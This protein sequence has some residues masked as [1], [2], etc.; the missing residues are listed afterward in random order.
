VSKTAKLLREL[1]AIPSVNPGLLPA[2]DHH[3]GE[4]QVGEFIAGIA[5]RA[6]LEVEFRPVAPARANLLAVLAPQGKPRQRVLLAPHLDTVG[7]PSA[8]PDLF[9]PRVLNGRMYGRGACDTKG[10]IAVML[11]AL[12]HV[13]GIPNRPKHTEIVF[14]GLVDEEYLQTGSR[15]L[16]DSGYTADLA[17]VGEPTRL[18][19]VT[20]HKGAVWLQIQT[21]GKAAHGAR[22][23]LGRNA[24]Y[25][26]AK[27]VRILEDEYPRKYLARRHALLG[28]PTISVGSIKGGNQPNIV[29]AECVI[30]VDR[31]TLPG[32]TDERVIAQ[33]RG[34]FRRHR[35]TA[36]VR[37]LHSVPCPSL[38][39]D[40]RLPLVRQFMRAAGQKQPSG[41][42]FFSDAAV[43]ASGGIPSVL[44][45]PGDIAQAH[46]ADEWVALEQLERGRAILTRFLQSLD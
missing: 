10:S 2:G 27:V 1:I 14:A 17:I 16:A 7:V 30:T 5:S 18:K 22:P 45:G 39:T 24:V 4:Q 44:F 42:V 23:E 6:G 25:E 29:P 46:T 3:A 21:R 11:S 32:E 15:A 34:E 35:L 9:R 36:D 13:A 38:D 31:R 20:A 19:V 41:V 12:I 40:A 43:L 8:V 28:H 37:K 33:L 26:M